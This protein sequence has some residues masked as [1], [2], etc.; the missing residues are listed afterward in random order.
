VL[1]RDAM[2]DLLEARHASQ[3]RR[4]GLQLFYKAQRLDTGNADVVSAGRDRQGGGV[5]GEGKEGKGAS[6]RETLAHA[7]ATQVC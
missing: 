6:G 7:D 3:H 5:A 4:D 1:R 2:G